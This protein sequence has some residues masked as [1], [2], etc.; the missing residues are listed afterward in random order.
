MRQPRA[1]K[2][3]ADRGLSTIVIFQHRSRTR[4]TAQ[5]FP[6]DLGSATTSESAARG[7]LRLSRARRICTKS[8]G[9]LGFGAAARGGRGAALVLPPQY[10]VRISQHDNGVDERRVRRIFAIGWRLTRPFLRLAFDKRQMELR[11]LG[12]K[13]SQTPRWRRQSRS[14]ISLLAGKIQGIFFV[15]AFGCSCWPEI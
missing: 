2:I 11:G 14:Q 7:I 8:A 9:R 4:T 3:G 10:S 12:T 5:G 6:P 15:W 13:S 1:P